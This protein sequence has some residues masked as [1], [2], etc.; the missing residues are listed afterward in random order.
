M[1]LN[2]WAES[3]APFRV[4]GMTLSHYPV[5]F[6]QRIVLRVSQ[7]NWSRIVD[8]VVSFISVLRD[9]SSAVTEALKDLWS[10]EL[11]GTASLKASKR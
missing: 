5:S 4:E 7:S 10:A 3:S 6:P 9:L 11:K 1:S 8:R 2:S